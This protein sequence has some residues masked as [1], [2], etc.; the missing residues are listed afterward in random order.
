MS[1][2]YIERGALL[3]T[4]EDLKE[5]SETL[6]DKIY[7]DGVMAVIDCAPAADVAEVVHGEWIEC[8]CYDPRDTWIKCNLCG[9]ETTTSMRRNYNYCPNCGA[10]MKDGWVKKGK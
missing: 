7:L 6:R 1:K 9:H 3:K 2:E 5:K 4:F 8:D 10:K